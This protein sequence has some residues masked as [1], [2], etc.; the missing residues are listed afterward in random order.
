VKAFGRSDREATNRQR[1][2]RFAGTHAWSR[3]QWEEHSSKEFSVID[4]TGMPAVPFVLRDSEGRIHRLETYRGNWLLM[5][6]HR[7]LG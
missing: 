3:L 7:H 1:H 6:F 5:V 4:L 2:Y